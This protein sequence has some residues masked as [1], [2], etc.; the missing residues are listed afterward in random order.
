VKNKTL[1]ELFIKELQDLYDSENQIIKAL[2]GIIKSAHSSSLAST[3]E[4][5][6]A[7]TKDQTIQLEELFNKFGE[8]ATG[9][10][11]KGMEGLLKEAEEIIKEDMDSDVR[12][13]AIISAAAKV[14]HYEV[15]GYGSVH[16]F[17][18]LL[19]ENSAASSLESLL[20][21]ETNATERLSALAEDIRIDAGNA[22]QDSPARRQSGAR[23]SSSTSQ[24]G[25]SM[26]GRDS[27]PNAPG[28]KPRRDV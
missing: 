11:C 20:R 15:A 3:L 18:Q 14:H 12:D 19:G 16:T 6:L 28:S 13:A 7:I 22:A 10:K 1:R 9:K 17:A 24:S 8:K 2:P 4:Q 5:H 27:D 25:H 26:S 23:S 21:Q